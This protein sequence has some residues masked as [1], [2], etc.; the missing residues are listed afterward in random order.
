MF[1]VAAVWGCSP[2]LC[3]LTIVLQK[4]RRWL[5]LSRASTDAVR[6]EHGSNRVRRPNMIND[7]VKLK[8]GLNCRAGI[9]LSVYQ[10]RGAPSAATSQ[11]NPCLSIGMANNRA[12]DSVDPDER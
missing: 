3:E 12:I 8:G 10:A 11:Q 2:F 9:W 5:W 4:E 1:S 6:E 7:R